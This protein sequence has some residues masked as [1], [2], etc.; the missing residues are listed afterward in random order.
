MSRLT[1]AE[2]RLV[3]AALAFYQAEDLTDEAQGDEEIYKRLARV[4]A[5]VH[6]R[7]RGEI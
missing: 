6:E 3:N 2:W 1:Q 7:I 5:K 4:R